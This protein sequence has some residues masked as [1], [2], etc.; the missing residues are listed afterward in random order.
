MPG[1]VRLDYA[2]PHHTTHH[3]HQGSSFWSILDAFCFSFLSSRESGIYRGE[4]RRFRIL[5]SQRLRYFG[6]P[7]RLLVFLSSR[8][9]RICDERVRRLRIF[10]SQRLPFGASWR[11]LVSL[12][13]PCENRESRGLGGAELVILREDFSG[14]GELLFHHLNLSS[15]IC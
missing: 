2:L 7:W 9:S 6:V 14:E 4:G 12:F 3:A 1:C 11:L 10:D 15:A 8:E 5:D 13:S